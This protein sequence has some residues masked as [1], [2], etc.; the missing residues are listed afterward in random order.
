MWWPVPILGVGDLGSV[1]RHLLHGVKEAQSSAEM[2]GVPE[3]SLWLI[4][5]IY[6]DLAMWLFV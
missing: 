1:T 2:A 6:E 5:E 4:Q 3:N